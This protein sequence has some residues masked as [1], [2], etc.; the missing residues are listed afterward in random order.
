MGKIS[1][2]KVENKTKETKKIV[3][4]IMEKSEE[5][6]STRG[7]NFEG[8]VIKKFPKRVVI[9]F[10]RMIYIRKYERYEKRKTKLHARLPESLR[11]E[12][13]IGDLI[14][15]TECR[16][17]SKIIHFMVIGKIRSGNEEAKK[18]RL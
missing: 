17:L 7:R 2:N 18:W 11:D 16:P 14:Q 3:N 1:E 9:E 8:K 10:G 6:V 5:R 13:N 4:K 12:I 15:I